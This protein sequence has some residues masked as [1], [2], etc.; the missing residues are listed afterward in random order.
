VAAQTSGRA[1][2]GGRTS[3]PGVPAWL[4]PCVCSSSCMVMVSELVKGPLTKAAHEEPEQPTLAKP[5][6]GQTTCE[7]H[8]ARLGAAHPAADASTRFD[9]GQ[10]DPCKGARL[11]YSSLRG[12]MQSSEPCSPI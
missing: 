1:R 5:A 7:T 9:V 11:L 10:R 4:S 3:L 6:Q 2:G 12:S 8:D